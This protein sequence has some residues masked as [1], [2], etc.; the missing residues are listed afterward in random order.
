[1]LVVYDTET[2]GISTV[3]DQLL[4]FAA[5][6]TDDDLVEVDRF[7]IRCRLLPHVV[8]SPAALRITRLTPAAITDPALPAWQTAVGCIEERLR[9]WSPA[10]F[11]GWNSLRFDEGL[12]RQALYQTLRQPF[13]TTT[14]GNGR[15]DIMRMTQAA[16]RYAPDAVCVPKDHRGLPSF[17]LDRL[18]PAN[19]CGAGNAHDAMADVEATLCIARRLRRQAPELW[20]RLVALAHAPTV[21]ACLDSGEPVVLTEFIYNRPYSRLV[22]GCGT[23]P[24]YDGERAVFDLA[25]RPDDVV[26]LEP[27]ELAAVMKR[28]PRA[29]LPLRA[30]RQPVLMPSELAPEDT[31]VM[32]LPTGEIAQRAARIAH[33]AAF[34]ARVGQA[35]ALRARPPAPTEP[36]V[37]QRL[38][39]RRVDAADA[40]RMRAF[41]AA[42]WPER[43]GIADGFGDDRLC[44]LARRLIWLHCPDGLAPE[45][46]L[47]LDRWAADRVLSDDPDVPW[48]TAAAALR[49]AE[50]LLAD[51]AGP[52]QAFFA[53]IHDFLEGL[54]DRWAG[55]L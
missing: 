39:E 19:G 5:V 17:R 43:A 24:G 29:I 23:H 1:M 20:T 3:F 15:G 48:R 4:Q 25:F 53:D 55:C 14:G 22:V 21:Q 8:P 47:E 9:A 52:Q 28:R 41:H 42:S 27:V 10:V 26:G 31:G 34:H 36:E 2:T 35:L 38:F 30:T 33:D 40:D 51:T 11:L 45:R 54:A 18:A 44:V 13:L 7:E 46:R 12:L 50:T 37:E 16:W 49:E 6:L 32:R